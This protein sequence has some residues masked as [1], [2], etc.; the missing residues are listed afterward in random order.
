MVTLTT[1]RFQLTTLVASLFM[2]GTCF[3][4]DRSIVELPGT[5]RHQ[6]SNLGIQEG[7]VDDPFAEPEKRSVFEFEMAG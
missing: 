6:T 2:A 5:F 4:Q 3:A 1:K 7:P